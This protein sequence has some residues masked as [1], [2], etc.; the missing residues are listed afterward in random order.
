MNKKNPYL[1]Y[2]NDAPYGVQNECGDAWEQ[3]PTIE[4]AITKFCEMVDG[5]GEESYKMRDGEDCVLMLATHVTKRDASQPGG[6]AI[7]QTEEWKK[8]NAKLAAGEAMLKRLIE[9]YGDVGVDA[10]GGY[11][12]TASGEYLPGFARPLDGFTGV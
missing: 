3:F 12:W 1:G 7:E 5:G 11:Y 6:V 10:A 8:I 4:E 2:I 9:V